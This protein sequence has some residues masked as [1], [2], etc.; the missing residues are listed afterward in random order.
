[1]RPTPAWKLPEIRD[2]IVAHEKFIPEEERG[3][4]ITRRHIPTLR[5]AELF[6]ASSDMTTLALQ[7]A[8]TLPEWT[9]EIA[10]PATAGFMLWQ[11]PIG[12]FD[13]V[14]PGFTDE[15]VAE[16]IISDSQAVAAHW[17][18]DAEYLTLTLYGLVSS[19][20][21]RGRTAPVSGDLYEIG[22]FTTLGGHAFHP[23]KVE[24]QDQTM[25]EVLHVIGAS[26]LLMQQPTV[27]TVR[28]QKPQR[29]GGKPKKKP[30]KRD[31]VQIIDLRRLAKKNEPNAAPGTGRREYSRRWFVR[32]HW[33]QQACG[34]GRTQRKPVFVAPHIRGPED[35]PLKQG[36][37]NAW[38][39]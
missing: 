6:W 27:S 25:H 15:G 18:F 24:L 2:A 4:A 35:A 5:R 33:R 34:P 32:G 39:R 16:R 23:D 17:S 21:E 11:Q 13:G 20:A 1:M 37:V 31:M 36:R 10:A 19:A 38:R 14:A 29:T 8:A 12:R 7:A 30:A 3:T 26:W 9:P 28:R 22:V